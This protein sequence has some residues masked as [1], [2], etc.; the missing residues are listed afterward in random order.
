MVLQ[1]L[2]GLAAFQSPDLRIHNR[3]D[4]LDKWSARRKAST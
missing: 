3:Q 4:S 2:W 1:P